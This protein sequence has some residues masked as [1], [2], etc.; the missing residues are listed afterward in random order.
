MYAMPMAVPGTAR[1]SV[2][3]PSR[4]S[5]PGSRVRARIHAMGTPMAMHRSTASPE[6]RKLLTMYFGVSTITRSKYSQVKR[7]GN[8]VM[9]QPRPT[10]ASITPRY[11]MNDSS[12][13]RERKDTAA[14]SPSGDRRRR[15]M[16]EYE[17]DE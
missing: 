3:R 16:R 4:A 2:L 5:R 1:M 7:T 12:I 11:G 17:S 8:G 9:D 13:T 10:D 15:G 14:A 6:Y